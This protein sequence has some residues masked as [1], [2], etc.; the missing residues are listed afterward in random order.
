MEK[1]RRNSAVNTDFYFSF[2][3]NMNRDQMKER[4]PN[5]EYVGVGIVKN[6]DL[7]FNRKGSYRPGGVSSIVPKN[8]VDV[9]GVVWKIS[10]AELKEMDRIEDPEAYERVTKD[11]L[12]NDELIPCQ[13]Y[14]SFPQG[15]IEADQPYLE[16]II[17]SAE[18]ANL[19]GHWIERL[20]KYRA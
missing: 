2:G 7:V 14:I 8:G 15:D 12:V 13:T 6:H 9:Y 1:N 5:A 10:H 17:D 19:P 11:V 4:T 3:S 18:A 16:L 20:K